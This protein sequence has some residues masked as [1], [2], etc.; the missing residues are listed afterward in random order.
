MKE[1][2]LLEHLMARRPH[3]TRSHSLARMGGLA[4][5]PR[6]SP[7][8]DAVDGQN[9]AAGPSDRADSSGAD[10]GA[11]KER[12]RRRRERR[13]AANE[14][15][16]RSHVRGGT[17]HWAK[18][19]ARHSREAVRT[20]LRARMRLPWG[21][22]ERGDGGDDGND[23]GDDKHLRVVIDLGMQHLMCDAEIKSTVTQ[24]QCSYASVLNLAVDAVMARCPRDDSPPVSGDMLFNA[25]ER[26]RRAARRLVSA[27]GEECEPPRL[28]FSSLHGRIAAALARDEGSARWPVTTSAEPFREA[29]AANGGARPIRRIVVL[30]PD[31]PAALT[32]PP[33]P[34][35]VYV[36]GGLCDYKRIANATLDRA[37]AFGV[38]ARRLPIEET[39]GTN[40]N[41][42][43]LTVNQTCECLFRA[44]LNGGDWGEAL[45]AVLPRR[46][47]EEVEETRRRRGEGR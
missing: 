21:G 20:E 14:L 40:L 36:I 23:G 18:T 38:E 25:L 17:A 3:P 15:A 13:R 5:I 46:K 19:A 8:D 28:L 22:G 10:A 26:K 2:T 35:D 47:M 7:D 6:R 1:G 43:I 9:P 24:L 37:E 29:A 30:S 45:S 27:A 33:S 31:A 34:E 12:R 42:N 41:V 32:D 11:W 4:S 44:R 16:S 39:L